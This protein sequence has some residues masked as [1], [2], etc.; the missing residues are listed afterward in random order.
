M[1]SSPREGTYCLL[2]PAGGSQGQTL[3]VLCLGNPLE[4]F[5]FANVDATVK[6]KCHKDVIK[7]CD[8]RYR[9][10]CFNYNEGPWHK[11]S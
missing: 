5:P 2:F 10:V 3:Q 8:T 7:N 9:E 11:I 1:K 6:I 4:P